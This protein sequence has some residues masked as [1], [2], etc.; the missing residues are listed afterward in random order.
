MKPFLL[1]A[2]RA[3]DLAADDEYAEFLRCGGL[4]ASDLERRRVERDPLGEVDLDRYSGL[5]LGGSPYT[6][7]E[8]EHAKSSAQIRAESELL[9]LLDE[10]I[11]RDYPFLGACYGIGLIGRHQGAVVDRTY[12]EP[13]GPAMLRLTDDGRADPLFGV[14]P[15]VFE[16]F[17][18]HKEAI[19]KLPD[20]AVHLASSAACPVQAFR[21]RTNV[22]ATQFH[23]ELDV[24]GIQARIDIY[25]DYGYFAPTEAQGLKDAAASSNVVHP[26]TIVRRFV[27]LYQR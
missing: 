22:Y 2:T 4:D 25:K 24:P 27:E 13:V 7:S 10:V 16:A 21:V 19:A 23:P 20:H 26:P 5:I 11:D 8:P 18:G 3:E 15:D 17:L 6:I 1:L 12:P 14:L 9:T